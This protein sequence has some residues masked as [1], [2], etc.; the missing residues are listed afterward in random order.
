MDCSTPGLSVQ[1][2]EP[3]Q[4]HVHCM[5]DAIQLSHPL[6]SH[7]PPAFN[8][9]QHQGLSKWV[10]SSHQV[11]K[12]LEFPLQH[13]SFRWIFRTDFLYDG[14]VGLLAAQGTLKNLS[15][16]HSPKTSVFRYSAFF[17][18]QLSHLYLTT[19]KPKVLIKWTF[20][21]KVMSLLFKML[22]KLVIAFLPRS[23]YLFLMAE[24][25]YLLQ[26]SW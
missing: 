18:V 7:S 25:T 3:S 12:I 17:I 2:P 5:G 1:L 6:S 8:L 23:K 24:V 4:N 22:F 11:V 9:S 14:L 10:S 19:G 21:G 20:V 26:L 13:Q 15:Q 16:H